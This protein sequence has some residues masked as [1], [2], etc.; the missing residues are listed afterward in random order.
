VFFWTIVIG[1]ALWW[2]YG[3]RGHSAFSLSQSLK[4]RG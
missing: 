4:R 2:W 3:R 1:W